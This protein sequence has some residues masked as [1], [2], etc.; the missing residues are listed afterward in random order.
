MNKDRSIL[1]PNSRDLCGPAYCVKTNS[2]RTPGSLN[3]ASLCRE[4]TSEEGW[5]FS[6]LICDNSL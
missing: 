3:K 1:V 4:G 2:M 5:G 6:V